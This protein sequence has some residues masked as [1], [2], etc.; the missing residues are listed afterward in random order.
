MRNIVETTVLDTGPIAGLSDLVAE[1]RSENDIAHQASELKG[2]V[3]AA[4]VPTPAGRGA[5]DSFENI[6][7]WIRGRRL[8]AELGKHVVSH[9]WLSLHAPPG[10]SASLAWKSSKGISGQSSARVFGT[11]GGGG[12]RVTWAVKGDIDERRNCLKIL[13]QFEV[14]VRVYGY[15]VGAN[16]WETPEIVVGQPLGIS[17]QGWPDCGFCGKPAADLDLFDYAISGDRVDLSRYDAPSYS[18]HYEYELNDTAEAQIG[19]TI[20]GPAPVEA[21]LESKWEYLFSCEVSCTFPSGRAYVPYRGM[22]TPPSSTLPY[23]ALE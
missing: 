19:I 12:R 8:V 6:I 14:E 11:G 22:D 13:Q 9:E 4:G 7:N 23:W 2:L 20:G 18:Q 3:L 1:V 16:Y 5:G 10:G 15:G 21:K 17:L